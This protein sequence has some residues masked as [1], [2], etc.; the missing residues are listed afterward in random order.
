MK[1]LPPISAT[2]QRGTA[3]QAIRATAMRAI[4]VSL[5]VVCMHA[6]K[7]QPRTPFGSN[8]WG[9]WGTGPYGNLPAVT[10][11]GNSSLAQSD[12][13]LFQFG[14]DRLVALGLD[15]GLV[16]IRQD[17]GG[18]KLLSGYDPT[19]HQFRGGAG[20]ATSDTLL[21]A[22]RCPQSGS[23]Q[24]LTIAY[25]VG[26][27]WK[28]TSTGGMSQAVTAPFGDVSFV[29][30]DVNVTVPGALAYTEIWGGL[31]EELRDGQLDR[32]ASATWT[33]NITI[34]CVTE[35]LQLRLTRPISTATAAG[36][37]SP[38]DLAI[39]ILDERTAPY[40]PKGVWDKPF[41]RPSAHDPAPRAVFLAALL[42]KAASTSTIS[43]CT[44][45]TALIPNIDMPEAP[46]VVG[47]LCGQVVDAGPATAFALQ[48]P[49][50]A[51]FRGA[52]H[53]FSVLLAHGYIPD[54]SS[55]VVDALEPLFAAAT[56]PGVS[57]RLTGVRLWLEESA[58]AFS[59][60]GVRFS[61]NAST[62][63]GDSSWVAREQV[64]QAGYTRGALTYDSFWSSPLINQ[65]GVYQYRAGFQ[66]AA[67]DP[68]SHVQ[69]LLFDMDTRRA[70]GKPGRIAVP[71]LNETVVAK[72]VRMTVAQ[73]DANWTVPW[74]LQEYGLPYAEDYASSTGTSMH[75]SDL[76]IWTLGA[77][78]RYV[79][80]TRDTAFLSGQI[81][82]NASS[83]GDAGAIALADA[84]WQLF[85]RLRDVIGTGVHGLIRMLHMGELGAHLCLS[86]SA[87]ADMCDRSP[88]GVCCPC[89]QS[90]L[91]RSQ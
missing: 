41:P 72:M 49:A 45:S 11:L 31:A 19:H 90:L 23:C 57:S 62:T 66:G 39:V 85:L 75:P 14:N 44:N 38:A 47:P 24:N 22:T 27:T 2:R 46:A 50:E 18:P 88:C 69:P 48:L 25:A 91:R 74:G 4:C 5:L 53:G 6:H 29:V 42:P 58:S 71:V 84:L 3:S 26:S 21:E 68:L 35:A 63:A 81:V 56:A 12:G 34:M 16:T 76:E 64:W 78:G 89:V 73:A 65:A 77:A 36:G 80:T 13:L 60:T 82:T 40:A 67:R 83:S 70:P 86:R 87:V 55:T 43:A 32:S 54:D 10:Y 28:T 61:P 1:A 59:S 37:C 51:A 7:S 52:E 8:N 79:L 20:W 17:E 30:S 15:N 33:H 9:T